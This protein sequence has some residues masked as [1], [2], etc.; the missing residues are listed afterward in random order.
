MSDFTDEATTSEV[1][2]PVVEEVQTP[3]TESELDNW[4]G[5]GKKYTSADELAKAY[6]NADQRI[7]ELRLENGRITSEK[8]EIAGKAKSVEDILSALKNEQE[9]TYTPP[10]STQTENVDLDSLLEQKLAQRDDMASKK[11]KVTSTWSIMDEAFG[12]H[13]SAALA[14]NSYID[15]DPFKKQAIDAMALSDPEGLLRLLGKDVSKKAVTFA[16]DPTGNAGPVNLEQQLT[17]E[18]AQA[19]RKS[20]PKLYHSHAFRARMVNEIN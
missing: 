18:V 13:K 9:A 5:E 4:V 14:V 17:W 15:G 10:Q 8:D 16:T 19:V 11:A 3:A 6:K 1:T 20:N 7:E 2:P 12:D